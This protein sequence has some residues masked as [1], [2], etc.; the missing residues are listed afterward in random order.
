MRGLQGVA[1]LAG[2]TDGG[3]GPDNDA[4]GAVVTGRDVAEAERAGLDAREHLQR[5]DAYTFFRR[6][7]EAKYSRSNVLHLRD[8]PTGTNVADLVVLLVRPE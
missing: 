2:G 8:G 5:C 3:D 7:E 1:L 4:A 6:L